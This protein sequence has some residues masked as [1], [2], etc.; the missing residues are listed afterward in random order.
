[1]TVLFVFGGDLEENRPNVGSLLGTGSY[2]WSFTTPGGLREETGP[3]EGGGGCIVKSR[4]VGAPLTTGTGVPANAARLYFWVWKDVTNPAVDYRDIVTLGHTGNLFTL[5]MNGLGNFMIA[6]STSNNFATLAANAG[7]P[8]TGAS[9]YVLPREQWTPIEFS[10]SSTGIVELFVGG[11]PVL[12]VQSQAPVNQSF[13]FGFNKP[14]DETTLRFDHVVVTDGERL[15]GGG[16]VHA[17][18]P[19]CSQSS[20]ST[21][22]Q[23]RGALVINDKRYVTGTMRGSTGNSSLAPLPGSPAY[24]VYG[25]FACNPETGGRWGNLEDLDLSWGFCTQMAASLPENRIISIHAMCLSLV[26]TDPFVRVITRPPSTLTARSGE[27]IKYGGSGGDRATALYLNDAPRDFSPEESFMYTRENGCLITKLSKG[28][29]L[30]ISG[31]TFA[32]ERRDDYYDWVDAT[33]E[34]LIYPSFFM[35]GFSVLAEGNKDF[36]SNYVTVQ[37]EPVPDG[38]AYIQGAWDY[39]QH[40]STGRW[41]SRQQVYRLAHPSYFANMA[42]LKIRGRGK[43]LQLRVESQTN[44]PFSISGWTMAA[45]SNGTV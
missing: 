25:V 43:A 23:V 38:G 16:L 15:Q 1:M 10:V 17:V 9:G 19:T 28:S 11:N 5:K 22:S 14:N 32:E 4:G 30:G 42:K 41:G 6:R 20:N 29:G 45:S 21:T 8:L 27:W 2:A 33:T 31:V 18:A 7:V 35:S 24:T 44:K 12:G 36:Q 13:E 26:V 37:Y 3:G 34:T 39:A 40:G